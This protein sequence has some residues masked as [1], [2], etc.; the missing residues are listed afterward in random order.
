MRLFFESEGCDLA[1]LEIAEEAL[2]MIRKQSFDIIIA[3][4][5]LPGMNGI[6]MF[7]RAGL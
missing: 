5:S 7:R 1:T 6:E 4:F 2:E 3:D